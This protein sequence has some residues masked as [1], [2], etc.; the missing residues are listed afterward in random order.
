MKQFVVTGHATDDSG[1]TIEGTLI[2]RGN[3]A[4]RNLTITPDV[5]EPAG[6]YAPGTVVTYKL[7][8]EDDTTP[9][10]DAEITID[11]VTAPLARKPDTT[12]QFV[13]TVP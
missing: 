6:G 9:I 3:E 11:G 8:A 12:D 5:E 2:V 1:L 4:P 7:A 10:Y 13:F